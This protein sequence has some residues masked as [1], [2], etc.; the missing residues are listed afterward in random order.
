MRRS[1]RAGSGERSSDSRASSS[2]CNC[3][4]SGA[5]MAM[6][7]ASDERIER[8]MLSLV[9]LPS[10]TTPA[11]RSLKL[12]TP[13]RWRLIRLGSARS[14]N[15][16]SRNSSR[17]IENENSSSP[18]PSWPA[19]PLPPPP[20]PPPLGRAIW[21]PVTNSL[22]PGWTMRRLPAVPCWNSG[23]LIS[24]FGMVIFSPVSRSV[25]LRPVTASETAFWMCAR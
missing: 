12:S 22:L 20:P 14:S 9:G 23:S 7:R 21:S 18:S 4:R 25:S 10:L 19:S 13:A 2:S 15:R 16:N 11:R 17:E 8:T 24:F 3:A 1:N 5:P 6:R